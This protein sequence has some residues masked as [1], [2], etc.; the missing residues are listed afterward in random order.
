MKKAKKEEVT[1]T[2]ENALKK[3]V[4]KAKRKPKSIAIIQ[5]LIVSLRALQK[6]VKSLLKK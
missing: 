2:V 1:V 3:K 6:E 5:D 4:V